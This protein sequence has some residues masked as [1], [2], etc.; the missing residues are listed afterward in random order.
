MKKLRSHFVFNRSQRNGIFLL[1]F[2]IILLQAVYFYLTHSSEE[3]PELVQNE[4]FVRFQEEIDSL[5]K[6]SSEAEQKI[7]PFNPNF[8]SDYKGYRLGMSVEEIDRLLNFRKEEKW[9]NS[10]A[11]FQQVTGVSDSL[12]AEISP[13]FEFPE[14]VTQQ[15]EKEKL[16]E[17]ISEAPKKDLNT[18][19]A[20][21]LEK[22]YGIGDVL[23]ARIVRYRES[24]GGF[25][26]EIQLYDVYGLSR[27]V[28]QNVIKKFIVPHNPEHKKYDLN[29]ISILELA[30]LPYFD[31][32]LARK[33]IRYR[34]LHEGIST[35]EE[36]ANIKDFPFDKIDR[37]KLYLAIN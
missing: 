8:I 30:E 17:K 36:L 26:D 33:V 25:R 32:E 27:E 31:Y 28:V 4:K 37:I 20:Q 23:A 19:E 16:S 18:A 5:K 3:A 10:V 9:I 35:F 6:I 34:K 14:W 15:E 12:L 11:Q 7:Y 13:L 29:S 22:I 24:I 1:V 21:E 2:L